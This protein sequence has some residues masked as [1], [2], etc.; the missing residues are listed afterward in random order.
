MLIKREYFKLS[1][2]SLVSI[3]FVGAQLNQVH[4]H[5]GEVNQQQAR[6][7]NRN[8]GSSNSTLSPVGTNSRTSSSTSAPTNATHRSL[9]AV[10][11]KPQANSTGEVS[12]NSSGTIQQR[13]WREQNTNEPDDVRIPFWN[14]AHMINSIDQI[15]P[16]LR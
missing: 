11:T 3:G 8:H 16:V 2:L 9:A 4:Q 15:E 1:L 6:R 5:S 12:R 7:T 13:S 14:I 10:P